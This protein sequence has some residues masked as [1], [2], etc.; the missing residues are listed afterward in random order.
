[1]KKI[2]RVK[3]M[4]DDQ[5]NLVVRV[6]G[7]PEGLPH[8]EDFKVGVEPMPTPGPGEVLFRGVYMSLDP[9]MRRKMPYPT[10]AP[11]PLGSTAKLGD[12]MIAGQTPPG[13]G[14]SG[15]MVGEVVESNHPDFKPGDLVH[16]GC[17]WQTYQALPA[18]HLAK[19]HR[20]EAPLVAELGVLGQSGFV[21]Y[22]GMELIGQVKSGETLV[23][24]AAGGAIGMLAGQLG[25]IAGARVIGVASGEK[26]RYVVE[27][28]GFD[29]CIDRQQE[30]I[31]P[32]LDRLC[33]AGIDVYFD[34]VGGEIQRAA[35]DRLNDF[36]RLVVCGMAAEYNAPEAD[37]GPP[38]RPVLR[39]RLKIQ[40]FVVYDHY[41][42]YPEF[43]SKVLKWMAEGKIRYR[44]QIVDG[45][46]NAPAGLIDLLRGANK[47]KMIVKL[48]PDPTET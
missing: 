30:A 22:C 11:G 36:G 5:P 18:K 15:G 43:R 20:G 13:H 47:G 41:D 39:K 7:A 34:N 33:P 37:V 42:L 19:L 27:E 24:S 21:A 4:M 35:F 32:A 16:G 3:K 8:V 40:G 44:E 46:A 17:Y 1:V 2:G 29:A 9:A 31:G 6:V 26:C 28:L 25:K 48:G 10:K 45:M 14:Y 23:V 38:L 12:L